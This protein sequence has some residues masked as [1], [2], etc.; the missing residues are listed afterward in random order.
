MCAEIDLERADLQSV[1]ARRA[2]RA[3]AAKDGAHPEHQLLRAERLGEVV[4]RTER[5]PLDAI[6]FLATRREHQN[7]DVACRV[8]RAQLVDHLVP[9][10]SPAASGRAR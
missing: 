8:V 6:G 1:A 10:T 3:E 2:A 7:G 5:E 9:R 4:V